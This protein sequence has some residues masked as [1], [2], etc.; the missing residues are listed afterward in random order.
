MTNSH[1]RFIVARLVVLA[2]IACE[3][4]TGRC[5]S[6]FYAWSL[7]SWSKTLVH[8]CSDA[9]SIVDWTGH[10]H[11]PSFPSSHC[12]DGNSLSIGNSYSKAQVWYLLRLL[13]RYPFEEAR[14]QVLSRPILY[15]NHLISCLV[16]WI[17][18]VCVLMRSDYHAPI[19]PFVRMFR[20]RLASIFVPFLSHMPI[21]RN[22]AS[23]L[24]WVART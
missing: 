10:R 24:A 8:S 17:P 9:E 14:L 12:S 3:M 13:T 20:P 1:C 21:A 16:S 6:G 19:R 7:I 22:H 15:S 11:S 23:D 18:F 4:R 5:P 2:F